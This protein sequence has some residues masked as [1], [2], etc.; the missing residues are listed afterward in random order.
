VTAVDMRRVN[1]GDLVAIG[2][3]ES[4]RILRAEFRNGSLIEYAGV[5]AEVWR[6][7]STSGSMWSYF[8]DN[9]EE[10]YSERRV[11]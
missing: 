4:A 9:V 3:D 10:N 1:A 2:F 6:R 5:S 11:R 8:R 7:L